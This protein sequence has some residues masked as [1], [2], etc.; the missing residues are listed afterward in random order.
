[1]SLSNTN[2]SPAG[3]HLC[4]DSLSPISPSVS[5][6]P[7]A[8]V[9][10]ECQVQFVNRR[11]VV[12]GFDLCLLFLLDILMHFSSMKHEGTSSIMLAF[13]FALRVH[14]NYVHYPPIRKIDSLSS[15]L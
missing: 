15:V 2:S 3:L 13:H 12:G 11:L 1:M 14:I 7:P 5:F 8:A 4:S 10:S 6:V 9:T